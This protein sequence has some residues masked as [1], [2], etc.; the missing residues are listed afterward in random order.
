MLTKAV[1]KHWGSSF[2]VVI[3]REVVLA[4]GLKEGEEIVLE[5]RRKKTIKEL[6]GTLKDWKIDPQQLKDELRKEWDR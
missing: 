4:E 1:V 6:F 2:G 3:P 5:I